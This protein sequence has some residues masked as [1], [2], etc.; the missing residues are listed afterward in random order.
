MGA[1]EIYL[2][3]PWLAHYEP[4]MPADVEVPLKTVAQAFDEL[5]ARAPERAAVVFY[6][7]AITY[8]ELRDHCG[9]AFTARTAYLDDEGSVL[10]ESDGVIALLDDRDLAR[11][12]DSGPS[13][14]RITGAEIA[15]RF[16][17]VKNPQPT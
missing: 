11:Y 16:P 2:S 9:R 8:R 3:R 7:R 17:F 1:T 6:G 14:Q 12:A 5:T 10:I 4:G 13:L 15:H